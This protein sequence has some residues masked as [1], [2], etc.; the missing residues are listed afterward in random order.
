MRPRSPDRLGAGVF[1]RAVYTSTPRSA[2]LLGLALMLLAAC[3][4]APSGS[5]GPLTAQQEHG[6]RVYANTCA[7]CHHSDTSEPLKGPSMKGIFTKQ[8]LPSG[9]PANDERVRDVIVHGRRDMP[10]NGQIL[11]DQQISDVIAYLHTL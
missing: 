1:A 5:K 7:A 4:S 8:F 11:G 3:S 2:L 6:R 9:A 10:P